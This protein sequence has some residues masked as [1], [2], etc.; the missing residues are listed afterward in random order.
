MLLNGTTAI[1]AD[2]KPIADGYALMAKLLQNR[3]NTD[4][5][6]SQAESLKAQKKLIVK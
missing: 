3:L 5:S 1:H 4:H 2:D 6:L